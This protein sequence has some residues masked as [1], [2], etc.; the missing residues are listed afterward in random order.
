M[1]MSSHP[2][3]PKPGSRWINFRRWRGE[4]SRRLMCVSAHTLT[5]G[6]MPARRAAPRANTGMRSMKVIKSE[7]AAEHRRTR[8]GLAPRAPQWRAFTEMGFRPLYLGGCFWALAS[9]LLW[10]H[11][12]SLL[13]GVLGGMPWHAHEMLW[14]F[15][16]PSP[17]VPADG[18]RQ[19][20]RQNPCARQRL[21]A[22]CAVWIVARVGYLVPGRP[23][24]VVAAAADLLFFL[25]AAAALGRAVAV[26]RNRRNHRCPCCCWRWAPPTRSI[27]G[28]RCRA[29]TSR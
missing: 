28:P 17:R 4:A 21:A 11:A 6:S 14:S 19:L 5:A 9:V 10:V 23:A 12:P 2:G 18:G 20:D 25:W 7:H 15:G 24:F 8:P 29:T 13:T 27:S 3:V 1:P 16:S 22:L 26:T